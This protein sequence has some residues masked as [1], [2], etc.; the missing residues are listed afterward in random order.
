MG[1]LLDL[2]HLFIDKQLFLVT[3]KQPEFG[4]NLVVWFRVSTHVLGDTPVQLVVTANNENDN[5]EH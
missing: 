2:D 1:L 4:P 5:D 3:K